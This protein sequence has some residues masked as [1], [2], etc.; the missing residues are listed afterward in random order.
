MDSVGE[1][2]VLSTTKGAFRVVCPYLLFLRHYGGWSRTQQRRMFNQVSEE[3]HRHLCRT[4]PTVNPAQVGNILTGVWN[5]LIEKMDD[6]GAS[7]WA[8]YGIGIHCHDTNVCGLIHDFD[9]LR[10]DI[11][12][13]ALKGPICRW[14][15]GEGQGRLTIGVSVYALPEE[16]EEDLLHGGPNGL[17]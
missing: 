14:L 10:L 2:G 7:P 15:S 12:L 5:L 13:T 3:Y 16:E 4:Y 6:T 11:L 17:W 8:S 1:G 9:R